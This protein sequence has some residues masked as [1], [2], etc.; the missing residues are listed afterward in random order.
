MTKLQSVRVV[1]RNLHQGALYSLVCVRHVLHVVCLLYEHVW[2][3]KCGYDELEQSLLVV[4][5]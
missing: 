2:S 3:L 4:L 5:V 1:P